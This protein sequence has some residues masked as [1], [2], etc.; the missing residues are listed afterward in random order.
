MGP[1]KA[2]LLGLPETEAEA[3]EA[4]E[5]FEAPEIAAGAP[6]RSKARKKPGK[7]EREA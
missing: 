1:S 4:P 5:A 6:E 2:S 3:S 7:L